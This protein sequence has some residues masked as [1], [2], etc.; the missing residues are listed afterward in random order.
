M[1]VPAQILDFNE[2]DITHVAVLDDLLAITTR[3]EAI[4]WDSQN[5]RYILRRRFSQN[6]YFCNVSPDKGT[7]LVGV[8]SPAFTDTCAVLIDLARETVLW[9]R[10]FLWP[11]LCCAF[12][13][14]RPE[15]AIIGR[16]IIGRAQ[17]LVLNAHNG[18]ALSNSWSGIIN[19]SIID[20]AYRPD[21][22]LVVVIPDGVL[23]F[24]S[25]KKSFS[26]VYHIDAHIG[27][28]ALSKDGLLL[29]AIDRPSGDVS[30]VRLDPKGR[31]LPAPCGSKLSVCAVLPGGAY[32]T[33]D[34]AGRRITSI[35]PTAPRRVE[36]IGFASSSYPFLYSCHL[37]VASS[38][39]LA[40]QYGGHQV[41]VYDLQQPR[42]K[43]LAYLCLTSLPPPLLEII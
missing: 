25:H 11:M 32:V 28:C 19:S 34:S 42:R 39:V 9:T 43:L 22:L 30:I 17:V 10:D 1:D 12:S 8:S 5:N 27:R 40:A 23:F 3:K 7:L 18:H 38:S 2:S 37:G 24:D 13:P 21:G 20:S 41:F 6:A 26:N 4:V 14:S 15:I 35:N 33:I 16:D 29:S 36:T 31:M